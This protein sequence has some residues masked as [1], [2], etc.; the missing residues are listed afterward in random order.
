MSNESKNSR[1]IPL[2]IQREVRQRCGFG[3]VICGLPLYEYE[4][5]EG[6]SNVKRHVADEIT[7]LCDQHHREKT[8]GLLPIEEVRNANK[9]PYNF[10]NNTSK[11]YTLHYSG[12]KP[13]AKIG[14]LLIETNDNG[15]GTQFIPLLIDLIPIIGFILTEGHFLLN[16]VI[17][18]EYNHVVLNVVNNQLVYRADLY[19]IQLVGRKLTIRKEQRNILLEIIFDTPDMIIISKANL[20]VNGLHLKI[21]EEKIVINNNEIFSFHNSRILA[22]V[23]ISIGEYRGQEAAI[24][25]EKIDRYKNK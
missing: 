7:L 24:G 4:H 14:Q 8:G 25:I 3:C 19:D 18:D 9:N 6:W 11:P 2:P 20:Y 15:Y 12:K 5:M 13:K 17:F 10:R 21:D 22:P 16:L 23:G 1:N